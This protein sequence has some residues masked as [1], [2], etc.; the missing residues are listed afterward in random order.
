MTD[1]L[2]K[3]VIVCP[4]ETADDI[5]ELLLEI[6]QLLPAFT[7]FDA[8]GH[9]QGFETA[10]VQERVR[11]KVARRV[12]WL[13]LPIEDKV[14]VLEQVTARIKNPHVI[15]WTEAILEFGHLQS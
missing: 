11:G 15:Y 12:L 2:C 7:T 9:G 1:T 4:K 10:S 3:L 8:D 6:N 14:R 13:V 5:V